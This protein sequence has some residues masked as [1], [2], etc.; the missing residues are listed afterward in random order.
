MG[1]SGLLSVSA[2]QHLGRFHRNAL[3]IHSDHS[4]VESGPY[5]RVRHP[6][7]AATI[8]VFV[9]IGAVLGNWFSVALAGLPTLALIRRIHIEE[10]MLVKA[11]GPDYLRYQ[12]RTARLVPGMW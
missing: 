11:L 7:Y 12:E 8:G 6:L 2:R 1:G 3:T 4:L 5:Q 9:G 10:D